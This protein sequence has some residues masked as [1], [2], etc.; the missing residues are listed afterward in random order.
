MIVRSRYWL[1]VLLVW[2]VAITVFPRI[3]SA[4]TLTMSKD[5]PV[6]RV[7]DDTGRNVSSSG[8]QTIARTITG[9]DCKSEHLKFRFSL[10]VTGY[11]TSQTLQAWASRSTDCSGEYTSATSVTRTCWRLENK[12]SVVN[13]VAT[14]DIP[15]AKLLGIGVDETFAGNQ[16]PLKAS[17]DETITETSRQ[18]FTVY[19]LLINSEN[20]SAANTTQQMYYSMNGPAAPDFNQLISADQSLELKWTALTGATTEVNYEFYCAVNEAGASGC[21]SSE[22]EELGSPGTLTTGGSSGTGSSS[23]TGGETSTT[24]TGGGTTGTTT[25]TLADAALAGTA[26]T[27][28]NDTGGYAG[29]SAVSDTGSPAANDTGGGG[30]SGSGE[31]TSTAGTAGTTVDRSGLKE[32]L[33]GVVLGKMSSKGFTDA[34]LT[35][36]QYYA[37]AIGV[38]DTYGN[39]GTLSE[40]RCEKARPV[41]T[42][43]ESYR[44][45]GGEAGGGF[46]NLG[47]VPK[48]TTLPVTLGLLGACAWLRRRHRRSQRKSFQTND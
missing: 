11:D 13:G 47:A 45:A 1:L 31:D 41:V 4:Q 23:S 35:N 30:S 36:G 37:V 22:L 48:R 5:F 19:F 12:I 16:R 10:T 8:D 18:T 21:K 38:R 28:G 7:D 42:F 6:I 32:H 15:P 3:A 24:H 44:L 2:G 14:I 9:S 33:C 34:N 43:F 40:Y 46:C 25:K 26:G 20:K 29:S 17:C 27:A 39:L